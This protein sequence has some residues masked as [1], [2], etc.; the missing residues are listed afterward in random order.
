MPAALYKARHTYS[1]LD[2]ESELE[3][4]NSIDALRGDKTIILI[5]HRLSTIRNCD[6]IYVLKDGRIV[7]L[8]TYDSLYKLNGEFTQMVRVQLLDS[9]IWNG[10][11]DRL[12]AAQER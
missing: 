3:V 2:T 11:E 5:A 6:T 8:G 1:S 4:Q 12:Y 10:H 9:T 7:E